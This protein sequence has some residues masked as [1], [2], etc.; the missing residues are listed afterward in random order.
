MEQEQLKLFD[1]TKFGVKALVD[2]GISKIPRI[3]IHPPESLP[4]P[5]K[6]RAQG[7]RLNVPVIDMKEIHDSGCRSRVVEEIGRAAGSIGF[8][9]MVNHGVTEE[10]LEAMVEAVRRFHEQPVEAKMELYSRN[11]GGG[12]RFYSNEEFH[13]PKHW[14]DSLICQIDDGNLRNPH[15]LPSV[16]RKEI[17]EYTKNVIKLKNTLSELLSEALGLSS[18]HLARLEC[19]ESG[20]LLCHYYPA[21]PEPDLT[22]GNASHS[23]ILFMTILMQDNVGGLQILH[24]NHWVDIE[25]VPGALIVNIGDFMQLI[26]NDKFKSVEH[27]VLAKSVGPRISV[28]CFFTLSTA[29]VAKPIGPIHELL[30]QTNRPIYK[31]VL[32]QD[33]CAYYTSKQGNCRGALALPHFK[34]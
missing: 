26:T 15:L 14:R 17:E 18:D 31:D 10:I 24:Q 9:Q 1:H 5:Q 8:F 4:D 28:G 22:L 7:V 3:F 20:S 11:G 30:S 25:P 23:D 34:L 19:L 29:A 6:S 33:Y 16:C 27:R 13:E 21:C 12:V 2:S 32:F